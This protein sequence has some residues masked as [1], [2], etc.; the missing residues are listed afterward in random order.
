MSHVLSPGAAAPP[1]A[2]SRR[3]AIERGCD[4]LLDGVVV[5]LATWTMTYHL[6]LV[7]GLPVEVALAGECVVL[8]GTVLL[9]RSPLLGPAD[10]LPDDGPV[11]DRQVSPRQGGG[12]LP[13]RPVRPLVAAT[14]GLASVSA[15]AMAFEA[16]WLV[17]WPT[18]LGAALA[19]SC[20]AVRA[21]QHRGVPTSRGPAATDTAVGSR[22]GILVLA[23]GLVLAA[24]SSVLVRSNPDDLF[25]LNV[26]QWVASYGVFPLR[27]TL[28]SDLAYPMAN[29]P[30]TASYDAMVG[31]IA[32]V[33]GMRAATVA[34]VVIT[35]VATFL[36]VL[37]LWRLLRSWRVLEVGVALSA[38]LVFLL[39]DGTSSYASPGNLFLTRLWQGKVILLCVLVPLLLVFALAHAERPSRRSAFRLFLGGAAAV[40][41]STTALFITPIIA[42]AGAAPLA[43][44]GRWRAAGVGLGAM[45]AYPLAGAA[46]TVVLG[47]RSADDFAS[48]RLFRFEPS[49][50]GPE[51]FLTGLV[52]AVGVLAVL[53]GSLLVPQPAARVTTGL[54]VLAT[55]VT[56]VPGVTVVVYDLVGLGPTLWRVSW[57]CTIA[58]LVGVL[59]AAAGARLR[60]LRWRG[61][62]PVAV[63]VSL[64]LLAAFGAPIWAGSTG[65][66]FAMPGQWKRSDGTRS[67]TEWLIDSGAPGDVVL[68]PDPVSITVAVTTT[69]IKTVA[70]RD[71]YMDYL[72]DESSF[73]FPERL[74]LVS[75]AN[76]VGSWEQDAVRRALRLLGVDAVCLYVDDPER[77]AALRSAGFTTRLV[78]DDYE[79]LR[80]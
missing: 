31:T 22:T 20:H 18:F 49:W 40:A 67:V 46:A 14:V 39:L 77:V 26:S 63:I 50:F 37:A 4:V 32:Y 54:L 76:Q 71:Y 53:L 11:T 24:L 7:L 69:E 33:G 38:A 23:W 60:S 73:L 75:F 42:V 43:V 12:V 64:S 21:V 8:A 47:G 58:A 65:S 51:I 36:S 68:A 55:A 56:F 78:T 66:G 62:V 16:P 80:R 48:R 79:C 57:G 35:P 9:W 74:V 52:A 44:R 28:F 10:R 3:V 70:P 41:L 45:A 1:V 15:L 34:Y 25:Y 2:A 5:V 19:G 27:D 29:W 61:S 30:P 13:L 17:V 6:C 72:R 59:T